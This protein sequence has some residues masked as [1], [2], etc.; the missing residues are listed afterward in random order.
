MVRHVNHRPLSCRP[1]YALPVQT[2]R[3]LFGRSVVVAMG[4]WSAIV[5]ALQVFKGGG[6]GG[7]A[8]RTDPSCGEQLWIP[9]AA[10]LLGLVGIVGIGWLVR[11]RR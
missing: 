7:L 3:A 2:L 9:V 5:L 4:L 8:C 11:D 6:V 1:V 10:W